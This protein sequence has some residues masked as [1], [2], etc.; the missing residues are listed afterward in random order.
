[1]GN[2]V[3]L[4][5]PQGGLAAATGNTHLSL[6]YTIIR[7]VITVPSIF[8]SACISTKA[9]AWSQG[10][11]ELIMVWLG[12]KIQI[13]AI[14]YL[15]LKNFANRSIKSIHGNYFHNHYALDTKQFV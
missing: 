12:W 13:S 7:I 1:M 11:L 5:N 15:P 6:K 8:I 9:I 3:C 4:A 14:I 2:G 10:I